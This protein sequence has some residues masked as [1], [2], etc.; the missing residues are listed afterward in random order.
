MPL[1][2]SMVMDCHGNSGCKGDM[3]M[4]VAWVLDFEAMQV[5]QVNTNRRIVLAILWNETRLA[6][7]AYVRDA[8]RWATRG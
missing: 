2:V 8:S 3:L 1:T 6:R 7:A 5:S 4:V